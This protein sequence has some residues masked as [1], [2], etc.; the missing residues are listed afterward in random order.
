M[1]HG[2]T[3]TVENNSEKEFEEE[4][5]D[6]EAANQ[7]GED[8]EEEKPAGEKQS[9]PEST[10]MEGSAI[11]VK[12]SVSTAKGEFYDDREESNHDG[13]LKREEEK[14]D[15]SAERK[16]DDDASKKTWIEKEEGNSLD[17]VEKA[18]EEEFDFKNDWDMTSTLP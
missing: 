3:V 11:M 10:M 15:E 5:D 1:K 6:I 8:T 7:D 2:R 18:L 4:E 9:S 17:L 13:E 16:P 12:P 14:L